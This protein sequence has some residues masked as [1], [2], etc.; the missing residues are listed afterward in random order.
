MPLGFP[1]VGGRRSV[2]RVLLAVVL[3]VALVA[4]VWL[5]V[6]GR[7]QANRASQLRHATAAAT[8]HNH[9]LSIRLNGLTTANSRTEARIT[10]I[11]GDRQATVTSLDAVIRTWNEWLDSSNALVNAANRFVDQSVPSGPAVHAELDPRLG[12]VRGKEAAF[13]AAVARFAA[14][15]AKAR[16]DLGGATP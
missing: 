11:D 12:T 4:A 2:L 1:D 3:T 10:Q 13:Q 15:A 8:A 6:L 14:A 9:E 5:A 16:H 7:R